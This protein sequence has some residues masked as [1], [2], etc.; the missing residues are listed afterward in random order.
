MLYEYRS[1]R[2]VPSPTLHHTRPFFSE[3]THPAYAPL[4][5]FLSETMLGSPLADV[6]SRYTATANEV[7]LPKFSAGVLTSDTYVLT[8]V[9][10]A[11]DTVVDV[12]IA[13]DDGD[14][15]GDAAMTGVTETDGVGTGLTVAPPTLLQLLPTT[16]TLTPRTAP[17]PPTTPLFAV[18]DPRPSLS[19]SRTNRFPLYGTDAPT[20]VP[21]HVDTARLLTSALLIA[22]FHTRT[23]SIDV[24]ACGSPYVSVPS[25][26]TPSMYVVVML[27]MVVDVALPRAYPSTYNVA[28]KPLLRS[29]TSATWCHCPSAM[30][31]DGLMSTR[32]VPSPTFAH[33]DPP[34]IDNTHPALDPLFQFLSPTNTGAA[35]GAT[36]RTYNAAVKL[37]VDPKFRLDGFAIATYPLLPTNVIDTACVDDGAVAHT[38]NAEAH[39][40]DPPTTL[41]VPPSVPLF[42]VTLPL[43]SDSCSRTS[44]LLLYGGVAVDATHSGTANAVMSDADIARFQIRTSSMLVPDSPYAYASVPS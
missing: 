10:S 18:Y 20:A 3:T 24:L 1:M 41:A 32:L 25:C 15:E 7:V 11:T 37:V 21:T 40:D 6:D 13:A 35:V 9:N 5:Q 14:G 42:A 31:N 12:G 4:P 38:L 19:C 8:L 22:R 17:Y 27:P 28:N 39:T 26:P 33:N 23:S 30:L 44:R 16:H 36:T 29:T 2:W 43:C 34:F